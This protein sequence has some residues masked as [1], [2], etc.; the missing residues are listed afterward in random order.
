[1]IRPLVILAVL[2]AALPT[3]LTGQVP[4]ST[5]A[6]DSLGP[7]Q[8]AP[9]ARDS[10]LTPRTTPRS[11]MI[12]SFVLPGWGQAR[13][14][15][16]F[17]GSIYFAGWAGNW[18]MNFRTAARLGEARSGL[19]LRRDQIEAALIEGSPNPD[20]MRAQIDS[21]PDILD[22]A[23]ENDAKGSELQGLVEARKDQREDWIAWSIFW[24]LASGIDAYVTGHLSDFPAEVDMRPNQDGSVSL[25]LEVPLPVRKE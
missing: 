22:T 17:R 12:R 18:F 5:A 9:M 23:V 1:M 8:E 16:Y 20:S 25:R 2:S 10:A 3:G 14:D 19:Q 21:F 15:A 4:D 13:Y 11:A 7:R 6:R 24:L